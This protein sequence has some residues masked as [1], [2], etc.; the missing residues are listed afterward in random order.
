MNFIEQFFR[1][2]PDDRSGMLEAAIL[3]V[4]F[5]VPFVFAVLRMR[6]ARLR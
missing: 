5:I 6:Y 2:S 4:V 1:I 3:V